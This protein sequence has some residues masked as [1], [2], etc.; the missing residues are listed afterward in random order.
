M[1]PPETQLFGSLPGGRFSRQAFAVSV[2]LHC[3]VL[4]I[5]ICV[6]LILV[7]EVQYTIV[8]IKLVSPGFTP[9]SPAQPKPPVIRV[10]LVF[11]HPRVK[12]PRLA[13]KQELKIPEPHLAP[14]KAVEVEVQAREVRPPPIPV[15]VPPPPPAIVTPEVKVGAFSGSPAVETLNRKPRELVASGFEDRK[16]M[17]RQTGVRAEVAPVGTFDVPSGTDLRSGSARKSR[18][19]VSGGFAGNAAT[20]SAPEPRGSVREGGFGDV[21]AAVNAAQKRPEPVRPALLGPEIISKPKP[22]Y[23][24]EARALGLQGEVVLEVLFTAAGD[25]RVL[26]VIRGLGHG[27]D[28]AAVQAAEQIRFK[29]AQRD[30]KPVDARSVVQIIFRLT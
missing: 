6:P 21:H 4:G 22:A 10:P 30:G 13:S 15:Q 26:T 23:T 3:I 28:E 29:P 18:E 24:R 8:E 25:V 7:P 19:I 17:P 11:A 2:A 12:E 5:L 20:G 9:R 27:L 1:T 16:D 14:K